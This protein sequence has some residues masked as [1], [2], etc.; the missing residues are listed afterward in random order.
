[1][2]RKD[3]MS[4]RRDFLRLAGAALAMPAL[5]SRAHAQSCPSKPLRAVVPF[6][7]GSTIDIVGRIV[8]EP[9]SSQLG[10]TIV[11][12][13]RGGAGGTIGTAAVAR[14]EPDGHTILVHASAPSAA[15]AAYPN[16]P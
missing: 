4:T 13:N 10:Q 7:P 3:S 1:M 15:P 11:V 16:A 8:L 5:C 6:T 14:A 2:P 12:E 9:L